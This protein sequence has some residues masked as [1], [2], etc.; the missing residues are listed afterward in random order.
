MA[1]TTY[2]GTFAT[3]PLAGGAALYL[4]LAATGVADIL[5][6]SEFVDAPYELRREGFDRSEGRSLTGSLR[7]KGNSYPTT[8][9]WDC[10]Y[11]VNQA[12]LDLF[13]QILSA[14]KA[15]QQVAISDHFAPVPVVTPC[16]VDIDGRYA[17][18][19][20]YDEAG[21]PEYLLQF[22]VSEDV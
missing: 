17:T 8:R 6:L 10:N 20:G 15:E 13:E 21:L 19:W 12:Q 3:N 9:R 2:E 14:Q 5:V 16:W 4:L 11:V 22:V 18:G 7:I 1:W